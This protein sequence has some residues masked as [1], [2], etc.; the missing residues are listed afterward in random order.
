[1]RPGAS[2]LGVA[3]RFLALF[4]AVVAGDIFGAFSGRTVTG[5]AFVFAGFFDGFA[6]FVFTADGM[7][8]PFLQRLILTKPVFHFGRHRRR[9]DSP[10]HRTQASQTIYLK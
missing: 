1:M 2:G 10:C 5:L 8:C 3:A 4:F 9:C 7:P 6:F